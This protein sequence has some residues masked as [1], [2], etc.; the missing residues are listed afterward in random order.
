MAASIRDT[1]TK[2]TL[3]TTERK[4]SKIAPY[5]YYLIKN[6][7]TV[8]Q[9]LMISEEFLGPCGRLQQYGQR[10]QVPFL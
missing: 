8:S 4:I 3:S 2:T 10:L 1:D 9:T 6:G 5:L 7:N